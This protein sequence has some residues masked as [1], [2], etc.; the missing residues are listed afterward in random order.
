MPNLA[1]PDYVVRIN[2]AIDHVMQRLTEPLLLEDVARTAAFSPF[3]FHRIFRSL[4][5]ETLAS[6]VKRARLER[7]VHLLSHREHARLT[8]IALACGFSSSSDFS[9][10]F[11]E[12]YG[13]PPSVFD[14][15]AFR[16][17]LRRAMIE[18]ALPPDA[19]HRVRELP[20]AENPDAF[21]VR[22]RD[23]KARRIAYIRV[24]N[25]YAG[26]VL[27]ATQRLVEWARSRG[28]ENGQWLGYQ[29]DDPEIVP[30]EK[31]RYDAGVEVPAGILGD[32]EVTVAEFD[33]MRVAELDIRGPIEVELRALHWLYFAWLPRSGYAPAHAPVFEAWNGLPFAHG[34]AHFDLRLH[35]PVVDAHAP[36]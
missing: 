26:G 30:R 6:F 19:R 25:A 16:L 8:D 18:G 20:T 24:T 15:D 9:R 7:A 12:Q 35:L 23:L 14:A 2:R 13:V 17:P 22:L 11:K 3:H 21:E 31:C 1:N 36:L 34:T 10:C 4:T 5:G 28:L 27:A 32:G 29:W 33:Q